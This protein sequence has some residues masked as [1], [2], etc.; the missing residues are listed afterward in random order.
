MMVWTKGLQHL[1]IVE[2]IKGTLPLGIQN[3]LYS[4]KQTRLLEQTFEYIHI[5]VIKYTS[6]CQEYV[7]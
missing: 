5:H 2:T 6:R 4:A 3:K 1:N 7:P